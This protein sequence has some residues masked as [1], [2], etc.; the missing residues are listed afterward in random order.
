MSADFKLG[1]PIK[2]GVVKKITAL[3]KVFGSGDIRSREQYIDLQ[4]S[5]PWIRMQSGV[6]LTEE[7]AKL[8]NAGPGYDLAKK[9]ILFGANFKTD[10]GYTPDNFQYSS[11][12]G[13]DD[14]SVNFGTRPVPGITGMNINSHNRF[15]SLRTAV[16]KFQ[17]WSKEQIDALEVLYMRPGYTVLLEWGH[18]R[19]L[20]YDTASNPA[21]VVD[22][23]LGI[24]FYEF[25]T[26]TAI[27]NRI[28]EERTNNA[29]GY[30]AII[31][32]IKNFSW[33]LRPDGGYDC[34]TSLV[35]A[36][37]LLE[38]YKANFF[39][40]QE[41][42]NDALTSE[43]TEI[44]NNAPPAAGR[45]VF[46]NLFL[47]N[48]EAVP[49]LGPNVTNLITG[50]AQQANA[51]LDK[52]AAYLENDFKSLYA[53]TKALAV[54]VGDLMK[55][56]SGSIDGGTNNL[57]A[58]V[59]DSNV[60]N[61]LNNLANL[62]KR[63]KVVN[64]L[65]AAHRIQGYGYQAKRWSWGNAKG[66]TAFGVRV[67]PIE[68]QTKWPYLVDLYVVNS[69]NEDLNK[70]GANQT[71]PDV[72]LPG[73]GRVALQ[74]PFGQ[75]SAI[76]DFMVA[77]DQKWDLDKEAPLFVIYT[78]LGN[79]ISKLQENAEYQK[80][81][82]TGK[83]GPFWAFQNPNNGI[84]AS[85]ETGITGHQ[86]DRNK[87]T[88]VDA[89]KDFYKRW[90]IANQW[91]AGIN[92]SGT[93]SGGAISK[94][95]SV[96]QYSALVYAQGNQPLPYSTLTGVDVPGHTEFKAK[97]SPYINVSPNYA[98]LK[99]F[100]PIADDADP[101]SETFISID[102]DDATARQ[103]INAG[104]LL[105]V[106]EL[107]V[108]VP[109]H[110]AGNTRF[111]VMQFNG[112]DPGAALS[113][114]LVSGTD[115]ETGRTYE[116]YDP[117]DDYVS[118]LHFYLRTK[119]ETPYVTEHLSG[120]LTGRPFNEV[121]K[122]RTLPDTTEATS[123][124]YA[125]DGPSL[126]KSSPN[127]VKNRLTQLLGGRFISEQELE[128]RNH[129]YITLGGLLEIIN[130]HILRSDSEYFFTFQTEYNNGGPS[131]FTFDDHISTDPR[132]CI[133][134]HTLPSVIS[135]LPAVVSSKPSILNIE[136]SINYI[137]DT[138]NKYIA[139]GGRAAILDFLQSILDGISRVCGGQNDLQL[140]YLEDG[141][142][143]HV[144]DRR[145]IYRTPYA[146]LEKNSKIN[147]YGL[148]SVVRN[149][150]LVS[151]LTPKIS[152]MIAISAQDS[153]YTSQDEA[154][155][156]NGINRGLTDLIYT[157]RYEIEKEQTEASNQAT[158]ADLQEDLKQ[159]IIGVLVHLGMFYDKAIVPRYAVDTQ[160]GAYENY[161][162]FLFGAD[163]KYN[164]G[165][166][167]TYN[168]IIPF[169]L[170]V[171]LYGISGINVMDTFVINK[172]VLPTTYGG[173]PS[174][175]VGFLVTGVEHE[176]SRQGWYTT[177][178]T[179][180]YN[181]NDS[182]PQTNFTDLKADFVKAVEH[183]VLGP[184]PGAGA[185]EEGVW[186]GNEEQFKDRVPKSITLHIT[187]SNSSAQFTINYVGRKSNT[188]Y[189]AGGIHWAVD[190]TGTALSGIPENKRSIHGNN[191][192]QSGIGIE[193]SNWGPVTPQKDGSAKYK[194][195]VIPKGEWVDL[196]W[197][198]YGSQYYQEYTDAQIASLKTTINGILTRYPIIKTGING[199]VWDVFG[200]TKPKKGDNLGRPETKTGK[201]LRNKTWDQP[202]IFAHTTGGG[203]HYDAI[204]TPKLIAMLVSLGYKDV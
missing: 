19:I 164:Q 138:L 178:K 35:T 163:T 196:G 125:D 200:I 192:N 186:T 148:N 37:D 177:L 22:M 118:K 71:T 175:P 142:V 94:P 146:D 51:D 114:Q 67:T 15:G 136:L 193:I 191:W 122:Y 97:Y 127:A 29:F 151:K 13:Y 12:P 106:N 42:I 10:K 92:D 11:L 152:S 74:I 28:I 154:T 99:S 105:T 52:I 121:F 100:E 181:V 165:G 169:E 108:S 33:T 1:Q 24:N 160:I 123:K 14:R 88:W 79:V 126:R 44:Q 78:I 68:L 21:G 91:H 184:P 204:P 36:G 56:K 62:I 82:P 198:Y 43:L 194:N 46:P 166:R 89:R 27:R 49:D 137:L 199:S 112:Y 9:N 61:V 195:E 201:Q 47:D 144:V 116:Y 143:F 4:G 202:G 45:L 131:Y 179:Q 30:D 149:F 104:A 115:E 155:G 38:S 124:L 31:G 180:I 119:I 189:N 26:A 183:I 48:A 120:D 128:L 76:D 34:S 90:K 188:D 69:K 53:D 60:T 101:D 73:G 182:T 75:R 20:K 133:L 111:L 109:L 158:Y 159:R 8:Y 95:S 16:V 150:N 134:P 25:N 98:T 203:S 84:G 153:A 168:F 147:I 129:V 39:L 40:S 96:Y 190:R 70:F 167:A 102:S 103:A 130:R 66:F 80:T 63:L 2:E 107:E 93:K 57:Y 55:G 170:Q 72:N 81:F 140:Q 58:K 176:V 156:F 157:K 197:K 54:A 83:T 145:G 172:E 41:E 139:T 7:K 117:N 50:F 6:N 135:T 23:G 113:G 77:I 132:V 3:Q 65:D 59:D 185:G 110:K 64:T 87:G 85:S 174:S 162:K 161:C 86:Q 17:C 32:T 171:Q 173:D 18:S 5:V 141:S 187:V